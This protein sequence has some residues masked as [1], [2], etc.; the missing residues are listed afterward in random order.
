[1]WKLPNDRSDFAPKRGAPVDHTDET[2]GIPYPKA[3][4]RGSRVQARRR[5]A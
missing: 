3:T 2:G 1:M 5:N 4:N